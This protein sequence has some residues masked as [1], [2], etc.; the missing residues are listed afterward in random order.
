MK[1]ERK[2]VSDLQ[3]TVKGACWQRE[4]YNEQKRQ[5][6]NRQHF[7]DGKYVTKGRR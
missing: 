6:C 3:R 5:Y 2:L 4:G 7:H 1:K